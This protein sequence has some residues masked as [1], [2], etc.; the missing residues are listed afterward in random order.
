MQEFF[1]SVSGIKKERKYVGK[2]KSLKTFQWTRRRQ[3]WQPHPKK[4]QQKAKTFSPDLQNWDEKDSFSETVF[5]LKVFLMGT[6]N[7]IL[8]A[9][10]EFILQLSKNLRWTSACFEKN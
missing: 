1:S 3:F 10:P 4:L 5:F 2:I 7:A 9:L 8:T 6:R